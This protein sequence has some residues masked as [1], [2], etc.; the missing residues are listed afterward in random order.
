MMM[1]LFLCLEA[2][3]QAPGDNPTVIPLTTEIVK[4]GSMSGN[5]PKTPIIPPEVSLLGY[6]LYF[7]EEHISFTLELRDA[8]GTLVY[9]TYVDATDTQVNLPISLA[10]TY[11]LRLCTDDYYFY[12]EITL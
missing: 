6:T 3:A 4:Q 5:N 10:G 8:S 7:C 2:H 11:E 1:C 12:G 9:T